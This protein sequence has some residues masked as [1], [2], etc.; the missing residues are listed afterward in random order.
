VKRIGSVTIAISRV[1]RGSWPALV[2]LG[3]AA[4]LAGGV[5]EVIPTPVLHPFWEYRFFDL[6]V[7][8][9]ATWVVTAGRPLYSAHLR[10]GLGFTYPPFAVLTMLPL[11]W[12]NLYH[13]EIAATI[14]NIA[15]VAVCAHAAVRM[16]RPSGGR[17]RAGWIAAAIALWAEPVASSIGY[18][19][20]DLVIT[21]LVSIDLAC[22]RNSKVGGFGIGMAAALKLTPLIFIPYLLLTRRAGM[23]GRA[24]ITFATSIAVAFMTLP[25]DAARYWG[26]TIFD[27]S[28][29]T[30]R[31][32]LSGGSP[33]N[34][35]L[36]G[37]LVRL[38]PGMMHLNTVW[39]PACLLV[40]CVGL[41][42]ATLAAR[43]GDELH[44]FL[45]TATTGLL[46]SPVSW[47]H[48]W[49]IIV[50]G[51]IAGASTIPGAG[52]R[53]LLTLLAAELA[54]ASSAIWIV[55]AFDPVGTPLGPLGELCADPY[56]VLG[57]MTIAASAALELGRVTLTPRTHLQTRLR[58]QRLRVIPEG[59]SGP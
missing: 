20:I 27:V 25:R 3:S 24:L 57:L 18:G 55:I 41:L 17:A 15:L 23:A 42:L 35:S 2:F 31:H 14:A 32:H 28:R 6:R 5:A 50:P 29:V 10:H 33:V 30:G 53:R 58:R 9:D 45:L 34:Q 56:V 7:Y 16:R 49:T 38:F 52:T 44:G 59:V 51:L 40:A 21:A 8:R 48:H 13:D 54:I 39:L 1:W 19:Q 46:V 43:R 12:L 26:G 36:R 47:T 37:A 4:A 11:R 22:G